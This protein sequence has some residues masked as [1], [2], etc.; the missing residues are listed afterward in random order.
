MR[1]NWMTACAVALT[2][3]A[4]GS[5]KPV[6]GVGPLGL[7]T[8]EPAPGCFV[9]NP[10]ELPEDIDRQD[11]LPWTSFQ[12][13]EFNLSYGMQ[14]VRRVTE[15]I[16]DDPGAGQWRVEKEGSLYEARVI[17]HGASWATIH[18]IL[19]FEWEDSLSSFDATIEATPRRTLYDF[20][21]RCLEVRDSF[22]AFGDDLRGCDPESET[23]F[24]RYPVVNQEGEEVLMLRCW[25]G[26]NREIIEPLFCKQTVEKVLVAW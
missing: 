1:S 7:R 21:D 12:R 17:D 13:H 16:L 10:I 6:D 4:C 26:E 2:G 25:Q 24:E 3:L 8:P 9:R 22:V 11:L 20:G 19:I 5:E 23:S 15:P 18:V 14:V